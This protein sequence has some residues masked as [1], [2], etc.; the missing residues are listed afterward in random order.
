ME[1]PACF[2]R[3]DSTSF[4]GSGDWG[5]GALEPG[6]LSEV[7]VPTSCGFRKRDF[8]PHTTRAGR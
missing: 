8:I 2:S 6:P 1:I 7:S 3:V 5:M 4:C